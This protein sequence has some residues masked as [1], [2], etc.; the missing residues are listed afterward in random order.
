MPTATATYDGQLRC[1][2][3]HSR[4]GQQFHTDA[5]VDNRGKGEAI[6]PTDTVGAALLTCMLTTMAI[7]AQINELPEPKMDG[8]VTKTMADKPR[9]IAQL[10]IVVRIHG[11]WDEKSRRILEAAGNG[12]PVARSLHPDVVQKVEYLYIN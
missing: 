4:S 7:A 9:R 5:P 6:S 12:C 8:E 3:T 11:S 10:D 1:T 2:V